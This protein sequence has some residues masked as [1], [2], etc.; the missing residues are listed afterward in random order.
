MKRGFTC[1]P[2]LEEPH[3]QEDTSGS[4]DED[5]RVREVRLLDKEEA[6]ERVRVMGKAPRVLPSVGAWETLGEQL[7]P[8]PTPTSLLEAW[9]FIRQMVSDLPIA[10]ERGFRVYGRSNSNKPEPPTEPDKDSLRAEAE[11]L[12]ESFE[13]HILSMHPIILPGEL[14]AL[15]QV[16]LDKHSQSRPKESK[17]ISSP[18]AFNIPGKPYTGIDDCLALLILALGKI[19][20]YVVDGE[21][22]HRSHGSPIQRSA[23]GS[24]FSD[25]LL[26][27]KEGA[28]EG[29]EIR[30][31]PSFRT[32]AVPDLEYF[33]PATDILGNQM[34]GSSLKHVW[35][36]ILAGLYYDQL[37]RPIESVAHITAAGRALLIFEP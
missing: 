9:P 14:R 20:L 10:L 18:D 15:V 12:L 24:N 21:R 32:D 11:I 19:C 28:G 17:P 1:I 36:H 29:A 23:P 4:R 22:Q 35:A 26:S 5:T 7:A 33:A 16:F 34:A 27:S 13:E 30:R 25:S 8:V 6:A 2:R 37:V 31:Q 3:E